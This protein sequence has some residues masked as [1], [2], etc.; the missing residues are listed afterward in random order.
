MLSYGGTTIFSPLNLT[1]ESKR[2]LQ[3]DSTIKLK[4]DPSDDLVEKHGSRPSLR[5]EWFQF[6]KTLERE[7]LN[8]G[9]QPLPILT[10]IRHERPW[11][12]WKSPTEP[13]ESTH[14][15]ETEEHKD[16]QAWWTWFEF[17]SI[18]FGS[19]ELEGWITT[20]SFG[21]QFEQEE[22][23]QR[24]PERSLSLLLG[25][26]TSAPAG[27]LA[28]WLATIY[29]NLPTGFFGSHVRSAADHWVE[30]HPKE[31]ERIQSHHPVH[32]MNEANPF[33]KAERTENRGQGFENSP[34]IHMVDAGTSNNLPS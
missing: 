11:K 33:Y 10:A 9:A 24:L 19:D 18:E 15:Q 23:T 3:E 12:D 25:L 17:S 16:E 4:I 13:F 14:N 31:A 21:R 32:A 34:R 29:R 6:S 22:S 26:A 2:Q 5:R 7:G 8:K 28:A 30:G 27:P 1:E 20:W